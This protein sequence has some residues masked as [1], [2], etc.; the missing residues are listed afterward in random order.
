MTL[1]AI[2]TDPSEDG[3]NLDIR[4]QTISPLTG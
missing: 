1:A 2:Y 4:D 3:R